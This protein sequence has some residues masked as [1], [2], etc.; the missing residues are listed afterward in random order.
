MEYRDRSEPVGPG[1]IIIVPHGVEHRPVAHGPVQIMLIESKT[2]VN[3]GNV[4]SQRAV[5]VEERI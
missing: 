4:S 2:V 3:T 5:T 1:E